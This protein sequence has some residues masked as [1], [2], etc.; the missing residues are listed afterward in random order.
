MNAVRNVAVIGSGVMGCRIA[1]DC[2]IRGFQ[3]RIFDINSEVTAGAL[4]VIKG[5]IEERESDGRLPIG[6]L[7]A[8]FSNLSGV[9][10]LQECVAGAE[11]I[12]E[13]VNE[14]PQIKMSVYRDIAEVADSASYIG[15]NTSSIKGSDLLAAVDRP[16]KF[17]CF[18]FGPLDDKKVEVM[19]HPGTSQ[20]TL[21][22]AMNFVK[23]IGLVP[24]Q[25]HKEIHGYVS[26]RIW[27]AVKKE[28]LSLIENGHATASDIDRGWM[29]EWETRM[30]PCGLMDIVGLDTIRDVEMSY[31]QQTG[32]ESDI[33]P[34]F[35]DE[36]ITAG[37]LGCKSG[38]GFYSYPDPDFEHPDWLT[39]KWSD[40]IPGN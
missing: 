38:E 3:T 23:E 24:I 35:L 27:R 6:T 11:L 5:Y 1:Y 29:L 14:N 39:A 31:Y 37:K 2:I 18:N 15:S 34:A 28:A 21:Q 33:P 25:V 19:G 36:M 20:E 40:P 7:D 30:G 13:T 12:I 32:D 16:D 17:F 9:E 8:S 10:T 22:L 4:D 26:N